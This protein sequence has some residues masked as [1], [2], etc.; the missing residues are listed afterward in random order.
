MTLINIGSRIRELRKEQ[1][2]SAKEIAVSL[3]VTPSFISGI[4]KGTTKCSLDNLDKICV[5]LGVSLAEFFSEESDHFS[6]EIN[7]VI[8]KVKRLSTRQLKILEATLDEWKT[9]EYDKS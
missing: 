5:V 7:R 3:G 2:I 6:P 1:G 4:E 8:E 9:D